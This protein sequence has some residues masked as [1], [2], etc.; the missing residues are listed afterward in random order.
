VLTSAV[1]RWPG[2][3]TDYPL[4]KVL[5]TR[6]L[7]PDF[8]SDFSIFAYTQRDVLKIRPKSKHEI[9]LFHSLRVI[10]YNIF[11][12]WNFPPVASN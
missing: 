9:H 12:V 5:G 2:S 10:L 7:R 4:S 3:H 6:F 8:F 1:H 11:N